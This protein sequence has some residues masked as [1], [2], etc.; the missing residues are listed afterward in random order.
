MPFSLGLP[1]STACLGNPLLASV[2]FLVLVAVGWA[3]LKINHDQLLNQSTNQSIIAAC[4]ADGILAFC[5]FASKTLICTEK[6]FENCKTVHIFAY[7]IK[8]ARAVKQKVWNEAENRERDSYA[9]LYQFLYW[10]WEKKTTVLQSKQ[11]AKS[12]TRADKQFRQLRS[13]IDG[14]V[15]HSN[16][17]SVSLSVQ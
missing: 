6:Q 10:F 5:C 17:Q 15:N 3:V 11:F 14:D 12:L 13:L 7:L 16:N 1:Q 2:P 9:T 8:Y 4:L